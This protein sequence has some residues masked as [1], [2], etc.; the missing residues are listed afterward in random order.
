LARVKLVPFP[1]STRAEA[2]TNNGTVIRSA[3]ALRHPKALQQPKALRH[4]RA[5]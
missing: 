5:L 4:P 2:R 1:S 3:E